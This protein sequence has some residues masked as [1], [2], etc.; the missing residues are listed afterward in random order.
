MFAKIT[1]LRSTLIA[2]AFLL[3]MVALLNQTVTARLAPTPV[4][5]Q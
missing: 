3:A 5:H 2:L 4:P 1:K